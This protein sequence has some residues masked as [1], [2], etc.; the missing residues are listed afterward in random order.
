MLPAFNGVVPEELKVLYP[1]SS[2]S[3]L[4]PWADFPEEYTCNYILSST[5]PLFVEIGS[6]FIKMQQEEFGQHTHIYNADTFNENEPTSADP[7]YLRGSSSSVYT[8]MITAD[9]DAIWLMQDWLFRNDADFWNDDAIAAYLGGVPDDGM[10]IL[11]LSSDEFPQWQ[12]LTA[13]NKSFI[14]CVLHNYGGARALYGNLTNLAVEPLA[15]L[16]T[17]PKL[18]VGTGLTME[19]IDQNPVIYEFMIEV[20]KSQIPIDPKSWLQSYAERRYSISGSNA[21]VANIAWQQLFVTVYNGTEGC[22]RASTTQPCCGGE[23]GCCLYRSIITMK[24]DLE[25]TQVISIPAEPMVQVWSLI[26]T[27]G[28][29][30][31]TPAWRYDL[32]DVGRQVMA[33]LFWDLYVLWKAAYMRRAFSSFRSISTYL[34]TLISDWDRLL[35]THEA[36]LLGTWLEDAKLWANDTGEEQLYNF[37]ARNQ[38]TLWGPSGQIDDYAAKNWAGLVGGYY[39][40]RWQLL[41]DY[42]SS[43]IESGLPFDIE[44]YDNDELEI[45]QTFC[46]DESKFPTVTVGSTSEVSFEL[47]KK[48]GSLYL[49]PFGYDIIVNTDIHGSEDLV[50]N[51]TWTKSIAQLQFLCDADPLCLA[52]TTT[53]FLKAGTDG[54]VAVQGIDVYVKL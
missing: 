52:F 15:A 19:A 31:N 18:F 9:P 38:L 36:F 42:M 40:P 54:K 27:A 45:G 4:G 49:S 21:H 16:R 23:A 26:Q 44:A 10:I 51:G 37:N 35:A 1:N 3:Q 12:K 6:S 5:D 41:T 30:H 43:S 14:W 29:L 13:N 7:A 48:Y 34:L 53:G 46:N 2:I 25:L 33:N 28:I 32:V 17:E 8:S 11:D 24:P 22:K 50:V 20:S 39:S 47:Q